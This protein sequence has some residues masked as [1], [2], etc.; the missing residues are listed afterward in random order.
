MEMIKTVD[1][2]KSF[3]ELQVLKGVSE[4]IEKGEVVSIIGPSGGGNTT[5]Y[6]NAKTYSVMPHGCI[7]ITCGI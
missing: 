2:H 7:S 6:G 4:T 3:G 1:L 5:L